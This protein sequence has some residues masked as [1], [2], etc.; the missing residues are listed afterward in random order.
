[1]NKQTAEDMTTK[2]LVEHILEQEKELFSEQIINEI[3]MQ[4][5][6]LENLLEIQVEEEQIQIYNYMIEGFKKM[7]NLDAGR[8]KKIEFVKRNFHD[9]IFE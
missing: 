7:L 9:Y 1:M 4:I 2:E 8:R 3:Q 5:A 6:I